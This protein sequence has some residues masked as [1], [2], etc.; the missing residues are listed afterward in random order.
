[1]SWA[2]FVP[3]GLASYFPVILLIREVGLRLCTRRNGH[4]GNRSP[5]CIFRVGCSQLPKGGGK[6][7]TIFRRDETRIL[8]SS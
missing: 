1:M 2:L 4:V 5:F 8:Y 7:L 3:A 6:L